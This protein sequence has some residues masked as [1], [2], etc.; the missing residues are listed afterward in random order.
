[1]GRCV[2]CQLDANLDAVRPPKE[3]LRGFQRQLPG[4]FPAVAPIAVRTFAG[5]A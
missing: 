1:M 3:L 2:V 5:V 4:R